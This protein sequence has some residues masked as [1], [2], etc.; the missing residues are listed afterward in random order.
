MERLLQDDYHYEFFAAAGTGPATFDSEPQSHTFSDN[1]GDIGVG[2]FNNDGNLDYIA[3]VSG[4]NSTTLN[5]FLGT[6]S[7][8]F[9]AATTITTPFS[10]PIRIEV[11][12]MENDGDLDFVITYST[13]TN[14]SVF[15]NSGA[16]SYVIQ[17][18]STGT[19][20]VQD[21]ALADFDGDGDLDIAADNR[22]SAQLYFIRNVGTGLQVVDIT[23]TGNANY[24]MV[25]GDFDNDFAYDVAVYNLTDATID[26]YSLKIGSGFS[27]QNSFSTGGVATGLKCFDYNNDGNLDIV[28]GDLG[29]DLLRYR[30]GNGDYTFGLGFQVSGIDAPVNSE[31]ADFDG[32]CDL[33]VMFA[34]GLQVND[35]VLFKNN[36]AGSFVAQTALNGSRRPQTIRSGDF[37]GDGDIDIIGI[38]N[39][40]DQPTFFRNA[41]Y[42]ITASVPSGPY[43]NSP[44]ITVSWTA[45]DSLA[46]NLMTYE[47]SDATGSF[48]SPTIL[49]TA[50][51][52]GING[53]LSVIIPSVISGTAYRIR[54][55]PTLTPITIIDNGVNLGLGTTPVVAV[56]TSCVSSTSTQLVAASAGTYSWAPATGLSATN[57]QTVTASPSSPT[58]YTLTLSNSG[59]T[60]SRIIAV[61][62]KCYCYP[63][64]TGSCSQTRVQQFVL[65]TIN[66]TGTCTSNL[67]NF[68][69]VTSTT[70][71]L[72]QAASYTAGL[73]PYQQIL[74]GS[75]NGGVW[76]DYNQDGDFADANEFIGSYS[77]STLQNIGFTVPLSALTGTTRVRVLTRSTS[78]TA[79]DYCSS[80]TTGETKDFVITIAPC[81]P[82]TSFFVTGGGAYCSGGTGVAI[83]L[84][85]SQ[86]GVTYALVLNGT[87]TGATLNGTGAA[88]AFNGVT[89]AGAYSISATNAGGCTA[90][91]SGSVNVTINPLP[92]AFNV[93]GSGAYCAGGTG[94]PISLSNSTN[95][96]T[97]RLIRNGVTI[98]STLSGTNAALVFP[99]QTV[100][101]TY[102]VTATNNTTLCTNTMTGSVVITINPLPTAYLIFGGGSYCAGGAG[103]QVALSDSDL[104][105][106][107][108]LFLGG[109]PTGITQAGTGS[110]IQFSNVLT[111]GTYTINAVNNTTLCSNLMIGSATISVQ[112]LPTSFTVSGGGAIC[113]SGAGATINLSGSDNNAI[114]E[115]YLNAGSTGNVISGTGSP[116]SYTG[117][118]TAGTYTVFATS[119]S[120]ISCTNTMS[121]SATVTVTPAPS[122]TSV[123]PTV[124][125][126]NSNF[127]LNTNT[128]FS[129]AMS[130]SSASNASVAVYG[131][132]SGLLSG[133]YS[134]QTGNTVVR[135][136][137]TS[138]FKAGEEVSVIHN[139]N[140]SSSSGCAVGQPYTYNF[141]AKGAVAPATF[142][143]QN[144]SIGDNFTD[145]KFADLNED[146]FLDYIGTYGNLKVALNNGTGFH[147][148]F[149]NYSFGSTIDAELGD[150][151]KDGDVDV[152]VLNR[153]NSQITRMQNNGAGSLTAQSVITV[154]N[155]TNDMAMADFN[156]DGFLDLAISAASPIPSYFI[157]IYYGNGV[158]F[159]LGYTL[160]ASFPHTK[161][162]VVDINGD[163]LNDIAAINS[164]D[165]FVDY[166][167]NSASNPGQ[168]PLSGG[169]SSGIASS[170]LS[171]II[172]NDVNN[173]GLEDIIVISPSAG[174]NGYSV[175]LNAGGSFGNAP[176]ALTNTPRSIV[177]DDFDGDSD[178]DLVFGYDISGAL[179]LYKNNSA[180]AFTYDSDLNGFGYGLASGDLNNDGDI[181]I[182][183]GP[184]NDSFEFLFYLDNTL[185]YTTTV[186]S[187]N[188][189]PV[190]AGN[191]VTVNWSVNQTFPV[192]NIFTFELSDGN[193]NFTTPVILGTLASQIGGSLVVT[194]PG[195]TTSGN[196]FQIRVTS[197][198][199]ASNAIESSS[200][201]INA[202]PIASN[203]SG[204]G[205]ICPGGAGLTISLANSDPGVEYRMYLLGSQVG[206]SFGTGGI[207]NFTNITTP[208][209]Y[210]IEGDYDGSGCTT[211]MNGSATITLLPTPTVASSNPLQNDLDINRNSNV[212][213]SYNTTM[214][215]L[216]LNTRN[217]YWGSMTGYLNNVSGSGITLTGSNQN[218]EFNPGQN[219][220]PGE[221][222]SV[223][224]T[225][226]NV[227]AAGCVVTTPRSS[228]FYA[229]ANAGPFT[230]VEQTDISLNT[231]IQ[232]ALGDVDNDGDIDAVT[233]HF[234]NAAMMIDYNDG[235]GAFPTNDPL[236]VGSNAIKVKLA[237]MDN[238]GDLDAVILRS[239]GANS[240]N[241]SEN[242]GGG[243]FNTSFIS[244]ATGGGTKFDFDIADI[245]GDGR[246][247]ISLINN[248]P[249]LVLLT[250]NGSFSFNNTPISLGS[251]TPSRIVNGDFNNDGR[252]DAAITCALQNNVL[253]C[254]TNSSGQYS[255]VNTVTALVNSNPFG[256]MAFD[257]NNDNALDIIT[258]NNGTAN[259]KYSVFL[260]NGTGT[261]YTRTDVIALSL[262]EATP[263][264]F[265][266]DGDMDFVT[267]NS[268]FNLVKFTNNGSGTFTQVSFTTGNLYSNLNSADLDGDFDI[269]L[270]ANA[271]SSNLSTPIFNAG[272]PVISINNLSGNICLPAGF[273]FGY[274]SSGGTFVA[275]NVFNVELSNAS[276]SFA[277]P[278]NIGSLTSTATS[279]NIFVF[280][281]N[282]TPSG[283]GYRIRIVSTS[284]V[285]T[286]NATAAFSINETPT[287]V[288]YSPSQNDIDVARN[289]IVSTNYSVAMNGTSLNTKNFI[290]SSI[291]GLLNNVAGANFTSTNGNQTLNFNSANNYYPG[292]I[293]TVTNT[294]DNL[295]T[296]GCAPS[297]SVQ[298]FTTKSAVAP[299]LFTEK[300]VNA[301]TGLSSSVIGDIDNNGIMDL[302]TLSNGNSVTIKF[303]NGSGSN[304]TVVVPAGCKGLALADINHDGFLEILTLNSAT[305]TFVRILQ[306]NGSGGFPSFINVSIAAGNVGQDFT[307][308]DFDGNGFPD[309]AV[310]SISNNRID[311]ALNQGSFSFGS[312][313][314]SFMPITYT[315]LK[316]GDFDNDGDIDILAT[317]LFEGRVS[318]LVNDG[319]GLFSNDY[320]DIQ[321]TSGQFVNYNDAYP[322]DYNNDN[323]L[324]MFVITN[325]S[326]APFIDRTVY[327]NNG[328]LT[329]T[330]TTIAITANES[331]NAC[332]GDFDGDGDIDV[333]AAG[334]SAFS[335]YNK[336]VNDGSG[337]FTRTVE[338]VSNTIEYFASNAFDYDDDKDLDAFTF[339]SSNAT[340]NILVNQTLTYTGVST[341]YCSGANLSV[342]YTLSGKTLLPGNVMTVQLSN[343]VGSFASPTNIG[344]LASTSNTGTI[345]AVIPPG[346]PA[347]NGY[348]IRIITSDGTIS[349]NNAFNI[350]INATVTPAVTIAASPSGAQC[351]GTSITYTPTPTN[352]GTPSYEWFVNGVSVST[353]NTFTSSALNNNDVVSCE[354]TSSIT[355]P[356]TNPVLSNNITQ[357]IN[358]PVPVSISISTVTIGAPCAGTSIT[359]TSS[360]TN[361]GGSPVYSWRVNGVPVGV[362]TPS[363]TTSTLNNG[364]IVTCRVTSS[365]TCVTG[366][367]AISNSIIQGITA[368]LP[369]SAT[370]TQNP[371]GQVC[372]GTSVTWTANVVN[373][374]SP[375]YQWF[376]NGSFCCT[377]S[378]FNTS[379]PVDGNTVQCIVTSSLGCVTGN[380]ASSNT[381]V[382]DVV[383]PS[384]ASVSIAAS[385]TGAQCAGTNIIYTAT[386]SNGGG[387]P[388]YQWT[389]NGINVG[390]GVTFA[391]S[392]LNNG[393]VIECEMTS[394]LSCVSNNPAMSNS[395]TQVISPILPVS[396]NIN[397]LPS[398]PQCAGTSIT[399][400]ATGTNVGSGSFQ[401]F[402]NGSLAG[403]GSTF[404]SSSLVDGDNISCVATSNLTCVSG[405]PA[406]SNVITQSVIIGLPVSLSISAAPGNIICAGSNVTFTALPTNG[407]ATPDYQWKINGSNVGTNSPTFATTGLTNGQI[408]TCELT[409]SDAC[410]TGNP[411]LSNAINMTVIPQIVPTITISANPGNNICFG[412]SVTFNAIITNGGATPVY[413]WLVNNIPAGTNSASFTTTSLN[414]N[415]VV[416]C[417]ITS[418]AN[419]LAVANANS[420]SILMNVNNPAAPVL[421][422]VNQ[423]GFTEITA[424]GFVGTLNWSDAGT[425][426]PRQVPAGSYSVTQT[427][428]GCTSINSNIVVANPFP[429]ITSLSTTIT[430]ENCGLSNGEIAITPN[431]GTSSFQFEINSGG[432]GLN[433]TFSN[434]SAGTYLINVVDA[435]GCSFTNNETVNS[436][437]GPT[438]LTISVN[439]ASC[440]SSNGSIDVTGVTGGA[441]GYTYSLDGIS[442]V[443]TTLF[444]G[445]SSGAY[446]I[447]VKDA[448]NC[449]FSQGFNI[450]NLGGVT[451]ITTSTA[452]AT[453]GNSNGSINVT[454]V[455]GGTAAYTYSLDG[456]AYVG[457]T[458]FSGLSSG[459]YTIF[460]KDA[461][462]CIFSQGFAINDLSGV[463][464]IVTLINNA[465]CGNSNGS[466]VVDTLSGGTPG[467]LYNIDGGLFNTPNS[468]FGLAGGTYIIGVQDANGCVYTEPVNVISLA[469]PSSLSFNITDETCNQAN[470]AVDVNF[471]L[472]GGALFSVTFAGVPSLNTSY[473][474]LTAG[475]Y[476]VTV[477]DVNGCSISSTANVGSTPA[478][479]SITTSITDATCGSNNGSINVTGVTG[480]TA[481]Y[482]YSLDGTSYVGTTLFSG[483]ASGAYTIFVQDANNCVF[484]QG[485]NINNTG[486]VTSIT[487]SITDATCGSKQW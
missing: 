178:L 26:V 233:I 105:I 412:A 452:D 454:S 133:A 311:I 411:A 276:G 418:N 373:G 175:M 100:A 47:L 169:N 361:G 470:G 442:Y 78:V 269:D 261:T 455:T 260:N 337:N 447:F 140:T 54:V 232:T 221:K 70:T 372:S 8:T 465:T 156:G 246:L 126:N 441:P 72:N 211:L 367:P 79:A 1:V 440:G 115:L 65:N 385:A 410:T 474:N 142:F 82:P 319:N 391:S 352:G 341:T 426:N 113:A 129:T 245:N 297:K 258:V 364:D 379:A 51:Q 147:N 99:N 225:T 482:T 384:P 120:G 396:V 414:N 148:G 456:I 190:C 463:S 92:T 12:D 223:V 451:S 14:V 342:V 248:S 259:Q 335:G 266:G 150:Y 272:A 300:N 196:A 44:T 224:N 270:F 226:S 301:T 173:D 91:M 209:V 324:D 24:F 137:P 322:A 438:A 285:V 296:N 71:S 50:T 317:A 315:R 108:E 241:I 114:Y 395:I 375:T 448:N 279:G 268:S 309:I 471:I 329:F 216:N 56:T 423:C 486:G 125:S 264:D 49:G 256:M 401:W 343:S 294:T 267:T 20:G 282:G 380:P 457:T 163:Y 67:R 217:H 134:L 7:G 242:F 21:F 254:L 212:T 308:N 421:N 42:S 5:Q 403:L 152:I 75:A 130:G 68:E 187:V 203:V 11:G 22:G 290:H 365:L 443:G 88:I 432:L 237:D 314:T 303:D 170:G 461:N 180:G 332:S 153:F 376:I 81:V 289:T 127:N 222:V 446:N 103:S 177:L 400:T 339:S 366:N 253:M 473:S 31:V 333:I 336:Y 370:I 219:F 328:L 131:S 228:E 90:V 427:T 191:N 188:T 61:G 111:A 449:V 141:K 415:D 174:P 429:E 93:T 389:V 181:D 383:A 417:Q 201:S 53:S 48:A 193:G 413:Q 132:E 38:N 74:G 307:V 122:V 356:S 320:N 406:T 275:G 422:F 43:C 182:A 480:G 94:V 98:V 69:I 408:V 323:L 195:G 197:N 291:N 302:V 179:Q 326:S 263:G 262:G 41:N 104:G 388:T 234:G 112:A 434:L 6:G 331:S 310:S 318:I 63:S 110:L 450:N 76:I 444:S 59:C 369:V 479:T 453:C 398:G 167:F 374:G 430:D 162:T 19:V 371:A 357:L 283:T 183:T 484:S 278:T 73:D 287:I 345:N 138:D 143:Q 200:F 210:T 207:L 39:T 469:G 145:L 265:D 459:S 189:T 121:G 292:E 17:S 327:L 77:G 475:N 55:R 101:G 186:T 348:S 392:T 57:T 204:G 23:S 80:N 176:V 118:T 251:N 158:T 83:N 171:E 60:A 399:F 247:D 250:N 359:Y 445:L 123:S 34:S 325:T 106:T 198:S 124:N 483:L 160:N 368:P 243:N 321:Y 249:Q 139:I 33:D 274:S 420:N 97:Y 281:P 229:K 362:A 117:I 244:V 235:T 288:S 353:S 346:T 37:D 168:F 350:S 433:N 255:S 390:T 161:L 15:K 29:N 96:V 202:S 206:F 424:S 409:S 154:P 476:F 435:N 157:Y 136:N 220:K 425:G 84:S 458:L 358:A 18:L 377:G 28:Y 36:G 27:L 316:N 378:T 472:G 165:S 159:S 305:N 306:N 135:F 205:N 116:I 86:S 481:A 128:T 338:F 355:C 238:D 166:F 387:S 284:P 215:N 144:F 3:V 208:G 109:A 313:L 382:M 58:N 257:A 340:S 32:D 277:S 184:S 394:S 280:I 146:G 273:N 334:G 462:S 464:S 102:T 330:K 151:D 436:I 119:T 466:I 363:F 236:I 13:S 192:G 299:F 218:V 439:D 397:A 437:S 10:N 467:Y 30:Q 107:Y 478:I 485:F 344:T 66:Y 240:I 304:S 35:M 231:P 419:C 293:V 407:G 477:L 155:T 149:T 381:I 360:V 230:F 164:S 468:F 194:I 404:V 62:D 4:T 64:Y 239:T 199:A 460:V 213:T 87:P 16:A 40:S 25:A 286:S 295:S 393:D 2:D 89:T 298:Q 52:G 252:I 428:G 405:N 45:T 85:G 214:S 9:A 431:G 312:L 416:T 227:S 351:A 172:S 354:M 95:G 347:G 46:S 386:P 349:I 271:N 402:V 185:V 487:S